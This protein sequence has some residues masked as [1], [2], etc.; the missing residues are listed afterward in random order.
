MQNFRLCLDRDLPSAKEMSVP[1]VGTTAYAYSQ[2]I[3]P[4][5]LVLVYGIIMEPNL[6]PTKLLL[7]LKRKCCLP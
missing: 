5:S 7:S 4:S 2:K 3:V 6:V 1:L